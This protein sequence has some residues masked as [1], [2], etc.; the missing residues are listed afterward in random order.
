MPDL[1]QLER[2][3]LF[4]PEVAGG[5]VGGEKKPQLTQPHLSPAIEISSVKKGAL[6][7]RCW[8]T[9]SSGQIHRAE[10]QALLSCRCSHHPAATPQQV[11]LILSSNHGRR[12]LLLKIPKE[13]DLVWPSQ[14][15]AL[16][17][18]PQPW[19][20]ARWRSRDPGPGRV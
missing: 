11:N 8:C 17:C 9:C 7:G 13:Y 2:P 12:A 4:L 19:G 16:V 5:E 1:T 3:A 20:L 14:L 10:R 18:G 6:A 15:W